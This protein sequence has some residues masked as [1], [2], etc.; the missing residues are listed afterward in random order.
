MITIILNKHSHA[1]TAHIGAE[2][3][4][5]DAAEQS[6]TTAQVAMPLCAD[7]WDDPSRRAYYS[8]ARNALTTYAAG[9]WQHPDT[10]RMWIVTDPGTDQYVEEE[11]FND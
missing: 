4:L 6:Y 8:D 3:V 2:L 1:D 10:R 9:L 5:E 7:T 11:I